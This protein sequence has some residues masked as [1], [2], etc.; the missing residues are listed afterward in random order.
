M[1]APTGAGG[2]AP[3]PA[4]WAQGRAVRDPGLPER[5]GPR[6]RTTG[7]AGNEPPA[8]PVRQEDPVGQTHPGARGGSLRRPQRQPSQD[9][10][11]RR[12][13]TCGGPG[14]A[15]GALTFA[16][17]RPARCREPPRR[18]SGCDRRPLGDSVGLE[19]GNGERPVRR[20][21]EPGSEEPLASP[22]RWGNE[23]ARRQP[24]CRIR[25]PSS[26]EGPAEAAS[27]RA[28]PEL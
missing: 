27:T 16:L 3:C 24:A 21:R 17:R 6:L 14:R 20:V 8:L 7:R 25:F 19:H 23:G 26:P 18:R 10:E 11:A 28:A 13:R 12:P 5:H 1:R 9:A 4:P 22:G 2:G 15:A